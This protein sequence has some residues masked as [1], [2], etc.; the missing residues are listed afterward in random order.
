MLLVPHGVCISGGPSVPISA[1][2]RH[3]TNRDGGSAG[4]NSGGGVVEVRDCTCGVWKATLIESGRC[5]R[6]VGF[7]WG[8]CREWPPCDQHSMVAIWFGAG[9]MGV[10]PVTHGTLTQAG[11]SL[12]ACSLLA[13]ATF[14]EMREEKATS[15][16]MTAENGYSL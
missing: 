15:Q 13:Y 10:T 11:C 6:W 7:D 16:R 1:N 9:V 3:A 4:A 12:A 2:V 5:L 8:S 14:R